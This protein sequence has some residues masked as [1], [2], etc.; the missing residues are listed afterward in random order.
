M[1]NAVK[2]MELEHASVLMDTK[3]IL[4][5]NNVDVDVSAKLITI[6]PKN[7]LASETSALILVLELAVHMLSVKSETTCRYALVQQVTQEIPSSY[8]EKNQGRLHLT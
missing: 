8:V 6:V 3:A 7:W 1:Q 5:M 4:S 2:I